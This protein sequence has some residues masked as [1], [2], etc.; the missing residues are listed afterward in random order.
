MPPATPYPAGEIAGCILH[1]DR[2]SQSRDQ[3]MA[4]ELR[5]H[6]I[7]GSIGRVPGAAC[8]NAAMV[9]F[10]SLLQTNVL[11]QQRCGDPTGTTARHRR[12][13]R[14]EVPPST[15]TEHP[16][17]VN[18]HRVRSQ[19]NRVAHTHGLHRTCHQFVSQSGALAVSRNH[20]QPLSNSGFRLRGR[21]ESP[22]D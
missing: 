18:A 12:L 16:R 4:R 10:W 7:V 3:A 11:N 1:A 14:A 9:S 13:D 15:S 22:S 17:R 5:R 20:V 21:T 6:D 2:G 8:D 19:A